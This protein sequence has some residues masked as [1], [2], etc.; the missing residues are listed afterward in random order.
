MDDVEELEISRCKTEERLETIS[1]PEARSVG[2][3]R[4]NTYE[5]EGPTLTRA[6]RERR[7]EERR[8]ASNRL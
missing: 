8:G 7:G 1:A 5:K 6:R 4:D 3:I 2:I